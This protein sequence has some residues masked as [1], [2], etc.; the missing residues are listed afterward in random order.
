M[1]ADGGAADALAVRARVVRPG[2]GF[3]LDVDLTFGAGISVIFGPSGSG[4]STT[5]GVVAG[6]VKPTTGRVTMGADVW[7][8]TDRRAAVPIERRRIAYVFQSLG[9][10]PHLSAL[11][12][13]TFGMDR[14]TPAAEREKKAQACLDRF[15]AGHLAKRKPRTFSGGEGQR[16]AL[17]RAFAMTPRLVLLDEP[18]SA[19]E[20]GLRA[21]FADDLRAF[22]RELSIPVVLV[23]H[24]RGEARAIADHVVLMDKGR[25]VASGPASQILGGSR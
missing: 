6:I 25:A 2:G 24:D 15:R 1:S 7:L 17:A 12:N 10:F 3:E 21:E 14:K 5:L 4:K 11:G 8:D 20:E 16:V 18:F 22:A 9:L 13:V 23:T 19:L